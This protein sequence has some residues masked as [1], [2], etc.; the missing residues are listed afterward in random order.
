M[1]PLVGDPVGRLVGKEVGLAV[2]GDASGARVASVGA[3]VGMWGANVGTFVEDVKTFAV[4]VDDGESVDD[5]KDEA[6]GSF[7]AP[8]PSNKS[9]E[10][11]SDS[12][13]D[14][15]KEETTISKTAVTI[16]KIQKTKHIFNRSGE[17]RNQ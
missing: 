8:N 1:G 11:D 13:L 12:F 9:F 7:R 3:R 5:V 17:F 6:V 16:R 4:G 14:I 15:C 2:V 10:E